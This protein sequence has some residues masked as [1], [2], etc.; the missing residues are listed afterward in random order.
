M[1]R[2][3]PQQFQK[4]VLTPDQYELFKEG[5]DEVEWNG[6]MYDIASI[7]FAEDRVEILA[8]RDTIETELLSLAANIIKFSTNDSKS[9][10]T[11]LLQYLALNFTLP[12]FQEIYTN[13]DYSVIKYNTLYQTITS[14]P[15]LKV[16]SPPPRG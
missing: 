14:S 13:K 4:I 1:V 7:Q 9:T 11:A 16:A 15:T 2:T 10:P 3:S 5:D 6:F 8:L 12:T